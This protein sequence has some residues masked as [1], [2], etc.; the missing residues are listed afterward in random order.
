MGII[1]LDIKKITYIDLLH[2][3]GSKAVKENTDHKN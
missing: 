1:I 2:K 3:G